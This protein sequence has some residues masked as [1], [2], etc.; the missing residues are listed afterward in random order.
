[1]PP[2]T[3]SALSEF[4]RFTNDYKSVVSWIAKAA[5]FAP[6]ADI[7]LNIGPPW[8][9]RIAVSIFVC[10]FEVVVLMYSFEF[11]RKGTA[12]VADIRKIFKNSTL[13]LPFVFILY[14]FLFSAFIVDSDDAWH[15]VIVGFHMHDNIGEMASSQP[16]KWTP[17]ELLSQ[18]HEVEAIWKPYSINIMRS[19][20]LAI[21]LTFWS[22]IAVIIS[23]FVTLQWRRL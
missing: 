19:L 8:P 2:P 5:V 6:L 9:S 1:M 10:I 11:W 20:F 21:W 17:K 16:S 23:A 18:F 15:R 3:N 13:L 22:V 4:W 7:V 12:K 14:V